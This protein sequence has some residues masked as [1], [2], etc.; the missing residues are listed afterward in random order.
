MQAQ[1]QNSHII[2]DNGGFI[3]ATSLGV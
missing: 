1:L 3:L 2:D